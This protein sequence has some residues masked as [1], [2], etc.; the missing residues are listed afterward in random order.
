[1]ENRSGV[2][3]ALIA[4]VGAL[5]LTVIIV[6]LIT[7]TVIG[8]NLLRAT[9]SSTTVVNESGYLNSTQYKLANFDYVNRGFT[10]VGIVNGSVQAFLRRITRLIQRRELSKTFQSRHS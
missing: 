1:M 7:S 6:F 4:G 5:I 8:A 10:I 3:T 9:A 2:V